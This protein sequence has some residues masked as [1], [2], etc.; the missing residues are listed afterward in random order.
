MSSKRRRRSPGSLYGYRDRPAERDSVRD[1]RETLVS[2]LVFFDAAS[3]LFG[4]IIDMDVAFRNPAIER[5][6]ITSTA[7][8]IKRIQKFCRNWFR[9][10]CAVPNLRPRD[11]E[12]CMP[13]EIMA[14]G[15]DTIRFGPLKPVG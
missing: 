2:K 3:R 11:F 6:T 12:G 9:Q 7:L 10:S 5:G 15:K 8:S 4:G 1:I 14:A 13:I